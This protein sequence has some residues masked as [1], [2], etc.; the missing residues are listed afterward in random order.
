MPVGFSGLFFL[1]YSDKIKILADLR[2]TLKSENIIFIAFVER[3]RKSVPDTQKFFLFS[4]ICRRIFSYKN[5]QVLIFTDC[6]FDA[7]RDIIAVQRSYNRIRLAGGYAE[8]FGIAE[9]QRRC[10]CAEKYSVVTV[11]DVQADPVFVEQL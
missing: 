5:A 7:T 6:R 8:P 11:F 1:I 10:A 3:L 9:K 4:A 2:E